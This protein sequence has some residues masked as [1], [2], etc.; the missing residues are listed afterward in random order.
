MRGADGLGNL[1]AAASGEGGGFAAQMQ[2]FEVAV[3]R[4]QC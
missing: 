3:Y 2:R 1:A 4:L